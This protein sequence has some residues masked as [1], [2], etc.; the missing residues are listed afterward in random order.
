MTIANLLT[1]NHSSTGGDVSREVKNITEAEEEQTHSVCFSNTATNDP[2]DPNA[3]IQL[4]FILK[5]HPSR[6]ESTATY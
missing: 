6:R 1:I 5:V 2:N 4:Y 3:T